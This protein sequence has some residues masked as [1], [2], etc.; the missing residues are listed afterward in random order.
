MEHWSVDG[1]GHAWS[2]GQVGG[3]YTDPK[4]PDASVEM[5][6]FFLMNAFRTS[7]TINT[8]LRFDVID[9]HIPGA[10]WAGGRTRSWTAYGAWF[11]ASGGVT[12]HQ[13]PSAGW[14]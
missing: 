14:Q 10:K 4:G 1:L 11:I 8:T 7:D 5:I 13:R 3:S 12:G 2:G 6:R 9:G